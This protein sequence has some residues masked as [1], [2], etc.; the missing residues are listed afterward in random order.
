LNTSEEKEGEN[1]MNIKNDLDIQY[2]T[3]K[4]GNTNNSTPSNEFIVNNNNNTFY[5]LHSSRY[6]S[7]TL[8]TISY[9]LSNSS[10]DVPSEMAKLYVA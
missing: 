4:N 2:I 8:V 6:Y 7:P 3:N 1:S 9:D 5:S 10:Y